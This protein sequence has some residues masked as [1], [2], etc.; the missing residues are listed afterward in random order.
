MNK[1]IAI[2]AALAVSACTTTSG[3]VEDPPDRANIP[4][5]VKC[6]KNTDVPLEVEPLNQRYTKEEW[7]QLQFSQKVGA[8]GVNAVNRQNREN[9][10]DAIVRTCASANE[11][12]QP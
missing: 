10:L 5:P 11:D 12:E 3:V 2:A 1:I 6:A 7:D 8:F 9:R 4:V